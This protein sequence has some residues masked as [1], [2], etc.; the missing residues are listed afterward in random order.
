M[1]AGYRPAGDR[2]RIVSLERLAIEPF[3]GKSQTETGALPAP[4]T[5]FNILLRPAARM[6]VAISTLD[7]D[8]QFFYR[9]RFGSANTPKE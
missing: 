8:T 2:R 1:V 3:S 9:S 4:F 6:T 5:V 7:N